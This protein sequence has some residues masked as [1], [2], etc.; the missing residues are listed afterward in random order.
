MFSGKN[1][2]S[3]EL[4]ETITS[5]KSTAFHCVRQTRPFS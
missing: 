2:K 3:Q 5:N 4:I 1:C